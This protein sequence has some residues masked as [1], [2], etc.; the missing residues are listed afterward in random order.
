MIQFVMIILLFLINP[1]HAEEECLIDSV[2]EVEYKKILEKGDILGF[3]NYYSNY[4]LRASTGKY[5]LE[6]MELNQQNINDYFGTLKIFFRKP[7]GSLFQDLVQIN[8]KSR[9]SI[10]IN[11][12]LPNSEKILRIDHFS[13]T[14]PSGRYPNIT[15]TNQLKK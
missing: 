6:N 4:K 1:L 9:Q 11:V 15:L 3:Q 5:T 10:S 8:N 2:T 14:N 13:E 7:D 12:F